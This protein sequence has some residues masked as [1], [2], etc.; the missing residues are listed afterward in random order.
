M[1]SASILGYPGATFVGWQETLEEQ[2]AVLQLGLYEKSIQ[3]ERF[4]EHKTNDD[5]V[6]IVDG[7]RTVS[8]FLQPEVT[9]TNKYPVV[10]T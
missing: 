5:L 6:L 3:I 4:L 1:V 9:C 7:Y 8:C 10:P 2:K